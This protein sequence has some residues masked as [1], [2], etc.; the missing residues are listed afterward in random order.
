ME[1]DAL[2]GRE[3]LAVNGIGGYA[4]STVPGL[5][6][7][8][9]HGLLV[10][11]MA[12][13]VRRMVLLSRVEETLW[14]DGQR[15]S[16]DCNEYPGVI[17][18]HGHQYLREFLS[19]PT[20]RWLYAGDGWELEKQ[21]RL[22]PGQN[23]AVLSYRL[24]SRGGVDL[25]IRPLLAMRP[26]H[27]LSYQWNGRL[28]VEDRNKH[29]HRVPAT[30]RTP[31]VFFAHDGRFAAA[32]NWYLNQIYRR[33]QERGYAGLEDLWTPGTI[34][35][36]LARGK[37]VHF[38]CSADPIEIRTVVKAKAGQAFLPAGGA[39]ILVCPPLDIPVPPVGQA[40]SPVIQS[41]SGEIPLRRAD[42]S[43]LG[44]SEYA[45][46]L[47]NSGQIRM[48]APP[49]AN[50]KL[51]A[52]RQA[53]QQF[54]VSAPGDAIGAGR[55]TRCLAGYPWFGPATRPALIGFTGLFLVMGKF[56]AAKSMLLSLAGWVRNGLIPSHFPEDG[57]QPLYQGAD[58]SLW[59]ANA[60]WDYLRYTADDQTGHRLLD[61]LLSMIERYRRG[62][63]LGISIGSDGLIVSRSPGVPTSWMDA[64]VGEWVITPRV[65][66]PVELN[67]LWYNAAKIA[68]ELCE[69]AG[70]VDRARV[71][72]ELAVEIKQSFNQRF[73]NK[74]AGCCYDVIDDH[75]H[76][77]SIRPNQLL[78][79]SLPFAV[80]DEERHA[81]VLEKVKSELLTPFSLRT[82]SPADPC[83]QGHYTG[84]IVSR[85]RAYHNGSVFP[86]LL[87]AYSSA[88]LKVRGRNQATSTEIEQS[89]RACIDH[90]QASGLGQLG[91]LFDGDAPHT[92]GGAMASAASVGQI[93]RAYAE[94]VLELQPTVQPTT[95][96]LIADSIPEDVRIPNPA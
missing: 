22:I 36:H 41:V 67:A 68:A 57:S 55:E 20:P 94:D 27:D 48:S 8:K 30:V 13:P 85:D 19:G 50:R 18:P 78:A 52:L 64:K 9:Y 69:R 63:D 31:E 26:I 87:G 14:H 76:D 42:S 7:R 90:L 71:L 84:G 39:D 34:R 46:A 3:W 40:S 15:F 37:T 32:P 11:A 45:S 73:W 92:P 93:L 44:E 24:L 60:V 33:E 12:P 89:L 72:N 29:H 54:I 81:P 49:G 95:S 51:D 83:Y 10:A 62:T 25:Q 2:L 70:R 65:G 43:P 28:L 4:C 5:N 6:T 17:Y 47:A 91:E 61:V 77:P 21:L 16:L 58:I 66:R 59:F 35:F 88:L 53:A 74:S 86:W 38:V 75:G 1:L 80:L 23:T 96:K 82:L 56:A 79:V